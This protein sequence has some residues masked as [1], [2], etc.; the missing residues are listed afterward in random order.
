MIG[1][2]PST[3]RAIVP[4]FSEITLGIEL[5][6]REELIENANV[7]QRSKYYPNQSAKNLLED[8]FDLNPPTVLDPGHTTSSLSADQ[9][10]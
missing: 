1:Q 6:P 2:G 10:I 4:M 3:I 7:C 8:F 5:P 9:M